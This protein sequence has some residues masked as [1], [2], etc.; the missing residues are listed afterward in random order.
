MIGQL[1]T[2]GD[3]DHRV[4]GAVHNKSGHTDPVKLLPRVV[5]LQCV[6]PPGVLLGCPVH[7]GRPDTVH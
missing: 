4:V 3:W 1:P 7:Q 6:H 2:C 5:V